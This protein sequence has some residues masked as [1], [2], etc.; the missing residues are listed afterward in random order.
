M[1]VTLE[2]KIA[3]INAHKA[4]LSVTDIAVLTGFETETVN[5]ILFPQNKY[6]R[7]LALEWSRVSQSFKKQGDFT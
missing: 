7:S 4:G 6:A 2:R 1:R 5:K 3:I